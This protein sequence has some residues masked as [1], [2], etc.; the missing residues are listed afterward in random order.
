MSIGKFIIS[1]EANKRDIILAYFVA[2][3]HVSICLWSKSD[4]VLIYIFSRVHATLQPA[5]YVGWSMV[6]HVLLYDFFLTP[7]LLPKC[8]SDL[9]YGPCPPA[10]NFGSRVSGLVFLNGSQKKS[11]RFRIK[12]EENAPLECFW[13]A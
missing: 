11:S 12:R 1:S 10:H 4:A 6:G 13:R 5:L 3:R 2:M 7:L 9:K 8:S